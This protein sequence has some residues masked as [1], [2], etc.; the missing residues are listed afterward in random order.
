MSDVRER[1]RLIARIRQIRRT[2]KADAGTASAPAHPAG[3]ISALES[4][5]EHLEH[6]LESLQ[7]SVH[8]QTERDTQRITEI[9]ARIQP[10]AL[11]AALSRDARERGLL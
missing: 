11:G 1:E 5:V 9:E 2:A 8:R 7:D 10:A 4:R 3:D 6:L